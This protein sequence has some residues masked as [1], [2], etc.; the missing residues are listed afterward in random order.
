MFTVEDGPTVNSEDRKE[1]QNLLNF[2]T[3]KEF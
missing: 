2:E 3:F 1:C